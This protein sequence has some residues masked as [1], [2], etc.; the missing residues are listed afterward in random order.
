MKLGDPD[1]S[2]ELGES[3][4]PSE[5]DKPGEARRKD[6]KAQQHETSRGGKIWPRGKA[7]LIEPLKFMWFL[8]PS[9][10]NELYHTPL[11]YKIWDLSERIF[12]G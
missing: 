4:A 9:D 11:L 5:P 3:G 6:L 8:G 2:G 10:Q 12:F 7:A 1:E